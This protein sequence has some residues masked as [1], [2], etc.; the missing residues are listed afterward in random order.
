MRGFL[1]SFPLSHWPLQLAPSHFGPASRQVG[2]LLEQ[3]GG[4]RW[5]SN[6]DAK[7]TWWHTITLFLIFLC[8]WFRSREKLHFDSVRIVRWWSTTFS[9][10][11]SLSQLAASRPSDHRLIWQCGSQGAMLLSFFNVVGP[12]HRGRQ[13]RTIR[14][15]ASTTPIYDLLNRNVTFADLLLGSQPCSSGASGPPPGSFGSPIRLTR[16]QLQLPKCLG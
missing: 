5:L 6:V 8:R 13:A 4:D 9:F 14:F 15:L 7:A 1:L 12:F 10:R 11:I 16:P 2:A 3:G